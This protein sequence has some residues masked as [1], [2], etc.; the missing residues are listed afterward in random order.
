MSTMPKSLYWTRTDVPGAE[1]ALVDDRRGLAVKG[2]ALAVDPIAYTCQY[3]LSTDEAWRTGRLELTVEGSGWRRTLRLERA[4]GRW[5][6]A[7]GEQGDLDSVL[8]AGG[9]PGAGLPGTEDPDSLESAL[10]VDVSGNP[11]FNTLPIRRLGLLTAAPGTTYEV[12]VAWVLLPGLEV[13]PAEQS[14]TALGGGRVRFES[15]GFTAEIDV[16]ADGYVTRYPGL[17]SR[18]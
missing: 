14:Y 9:H 5:R 3:E 4:A 10:D 6:A 16:D 18:P 8:R 2:V 12:T 17:A 13:I 15:E 1:H 7:T 11:L